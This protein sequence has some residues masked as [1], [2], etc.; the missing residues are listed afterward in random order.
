MARL[1]ATDSINLGEDSSDNPFS[2]TFREDINNDGKV[3]ILDISTAALAFGSSVGDPSW[4][5]KA[6][7][8]RNG[9]INILDI[10]TIAR[11][12]GESL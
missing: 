12:F 5:P 9:K 11:K 10:S 4:N 7:M 1:I 8:D 2:I 6:D 3:N